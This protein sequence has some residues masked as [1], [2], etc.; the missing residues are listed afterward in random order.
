MERCP[1]CGADLTKVPKE[2]LCPSCGSWKRDANPSPA[3]VGAKADVPSPT[4]AAEVHALWDSVSL[5]FAAAVYAAALTLVGV[6]VAP[7]GWPYRVLY[8]ALF[9]G[10]F[11]VGVTRGKD[12][13]IRTARGIMGTLPRE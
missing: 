5:T 10:L 13:I 11:L 9:A 4:V 7:L 8:A 12:W 6:L 1:D 3:T 2:L